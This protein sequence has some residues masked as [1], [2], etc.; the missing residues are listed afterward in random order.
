MVLKLFLFPPRPPVDRCCKLALCYIKT[1]LNIHWNEVVAL[2]TCHDSSKRL[3][4]LWEREGKREELKKPLRWVVKAVHPQ[5]SGWFSLPWCCTV[6]TR[7]NEM[8]LHRH[9]ALWYKH[10]SQCFWCL[11]ID[12]YFNSSAIVMFMSNKN[13]NVHLLQG[14]VP[15]KAFDSL[16]PQ[17]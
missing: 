1:K 5:S 14:I 8:N 4:Q 11:Y 16:L 9:I 2:K 17:N 15:C 10:L 12:V 7:M 13:S 6:A 3:R